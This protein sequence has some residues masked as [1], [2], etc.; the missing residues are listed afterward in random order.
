M[1]YIGIDPGLSGAVAAI[2]DEGCDVVDTPT[3]MLKKRDYDVVGMRQA[4]AGFLVYKDTIAVIESASAM[5]KQGVVSMFNFGRGLGLWEGLLCALS[6][7][8][9]KVRPAR[10]K[11]VMLSDMPKE[12]DASRLRAMQLFPNVNL[13]LKK[14]HG[15]A[16]ALLLAAYLQ[17][18]HHK[19]DRGKTLQQ[20]SALSDSA[21]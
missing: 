1:I 8:Y 16:D 13:S 11:K 17:D 10:W 3:L 12:K 18:T 19:N 5:P 2:T 6:I 21:R 14:H 15:R 4:L 7:P 9:T 20:M